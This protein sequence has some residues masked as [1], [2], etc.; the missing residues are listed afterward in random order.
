MH[1]SGS[2]ITDYEQ[3]IP[4]IFNYGQLKDVTSDAIM[5]DF[6]ATFPCVASSI[7]RAG[8]VNSLSVLFDF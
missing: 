1:W 5:V 3:T 7:L 2:L 8:L 4:I 6:V